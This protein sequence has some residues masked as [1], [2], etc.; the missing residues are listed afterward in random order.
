VRVVLLA[1]RPSSRRRFRDAA[2]E[3]KCRP[4]QDRHNDQHGDTKNAC[5]AIADN[6]FVDEAIARKDALDF[7]AEAQRRGSIRVF[8]TDS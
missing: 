1:N 7:A 4:R 3:S 5:E 8:K 2:Q 6:F